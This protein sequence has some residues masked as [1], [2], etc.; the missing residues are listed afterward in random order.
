[1]NERI[2]AKPKCPCLFLFDGGA[3]GVKEPALSTFTGALLD[4]ISIADPSGALVAELRGGV[5][6]LP[7]FAAQISEVSSG[8]RQSGYI[9]RYDMALYRLLLWDM[10]EA[11]SEAPGAPGSSAI[12]DVLRMRREECLTLSDISEDVRTACGAA[13]KG[14][15]GYV[16]SCLIDPGNPIQRRSFYDELLHLALISDGTVTQQRSIEGDEDFELKGAKSFSPNGLKWVDYSYESEPEPFRLDKVPLSARGALSVDRLNRKT[17]TTVEGRVFRALIEASWTDRMGQTYR[18]AVAEPGE[19]ILLAVLPHGKFTDYL[20]NRDHHEGGAKAR[21]VI[22]E[23]GFEPDDWRY[24]AAQFYDG[25]LLS[26]PRDLIIKRWKNGYG[27]RFNVFVEVTSRAGKCGVMRT[28][29]M[30]EPQKLPSLVTAFPGRYE[31][32]PVRPPTPPILAPQVEDDTWWTKLFHLAD[33]HGRA[34]HA[35]TL[36]TPMLLENYGIIED[37]ES[38]SAK[39]LIADARRGFARWLMKSGRGDREDNGGAA[40][41][42]TLPSQSIERAEA[43]AMAFARVLALN[44][45]PSRIETYYT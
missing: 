45:V 19:D 37:G 31:D 14:C 43:Y 40:I 9:Q 4:A 11:L 12:L 10:S 36:P 21:F 8:L 39:V 17:H 18:F 30:L 6:T 13:L 20:F 28:G 2:P 24:L 26:E 34:A 35:A 38:G 29:W 3:K 16:G 44:G 1:M 41:Y 42:C 15:P 7:G 33:E 23:L 25:L 32:G 22:D 27:A 5:A